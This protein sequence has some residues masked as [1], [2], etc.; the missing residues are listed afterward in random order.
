MKN[1]KIIMKTFIN[2]IENNQSFLVKCVLHYAKLHNYTKYTS[3]LEDAWVMSI[4]GL[5]DALVTA[6]YIDEKVPE[7]EV[8]H[9]FEN[10][11]LSA[12]D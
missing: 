5:S 11:A 8:D 12:L 3:T 1:D 9:E 6:I 10:N 2:L 4:S 7:I